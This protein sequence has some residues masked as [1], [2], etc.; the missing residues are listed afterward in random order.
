MSAPGLSAGAARQAKPPSAGPKG[1]ITPANRILIT[2]LYQ[3]KIAAQDLLGHLFGVTIMTIS[4]VIREVRPF[5]ETSG[6]Q[7]TVSTAR[8]RT[9]DDIAAYLQDQTETEIN[10][11]GY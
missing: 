6:H 5:L 3:R 2:V 7:P 4:R 1:K 11:A 8:F 10:S 9:P